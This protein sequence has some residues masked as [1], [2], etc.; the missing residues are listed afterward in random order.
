MVIDFIE[1]WIEY[2]PRI[3]DFIG[4]IILIIGVVRGT[5]EISKMEISRL[6]R[7]GKQ[8][9]AMQT[10]R[11]NIGLYILLA[12]DFMITADIITS[13][14]YTD[15]K[16]FISLGAIVVLRTIIGYFLGKEV[17]ALHSVQIDDDQNIKNKS[18]E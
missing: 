15:I 7:K 1:E 17:D 3:V 5:I 11:C 14:L 10:L 12:L 6:K 13:L 16:D 9:Q 8:F 2:L 18:Q 4:I